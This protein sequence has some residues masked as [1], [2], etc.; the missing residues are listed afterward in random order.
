MSLIPAFFSALVKLAVKSTQRSPRNSTQPSL[1]AGNPHPSPRRFRLGAPH[2][3][4]RLLTFA[5]AACAVAGAQSGAT[6]FGLVAVG[7]SG[8][9]AITIANPSTGTVNSVSVLTQGQSGLDFL[10]GSGG[11]TCTHASLAT[12]T[13]SVSFAPTVPGLR[14]GAVVLLDSNSN[15]LGT[16]LISGVG[17]GGLGVLLNGSVQTIAGN[18]QP[19]GALGD[20]HAAILARLYIPSGVALDGAGN[21]YIADTGDNRIRM[22]SATTGNIATVAGT[23]AAGNLGDHGLAVNAELSAPGGV[24]IDGAGNIYIADTANN[25]IRMVSAATGTITTVAG[26]GNQGNGGD[27]GQATLASLNGPQSV[28]LDAAGNIWIADTNNNLVREV[29]NGIIATIAGAGGAGAPLDTDVQLGDGGSALNAKLNTPYAV[30]FDTK[31]NWY[32]ADSG[33]NRVRMVNG[34]GIIITIA[35]NGNANTLGDGSAA[36]NAGL[37]APSGLAVDPAG[38]IYIST[39][40]S[41]TN[42]RIRKVNEPGNIIS[43][44]TQNFAGGQYAVS[45]DAPIGMAIDGNGNIFLADSLSLQVKE[46]Q[47]SHFVIDFS[48]AAVRQGQTSAPMTETVENDGNDQL[49][50]NSPVP[51]ANTSGIINAQPD[52]AATTCSFPAI[53]AVDG[54]CKIG[55]VFAP[56]VNPP[57]KNNTNAPET[58]NIDIADDAEPGNQG[59]NSPLAITVWGTASPLN[60]TSITFVNPI[61]TSIDFGAPVTYN[62]N[63]SATGALTGTVTLTDVLPS[64]PVTLASLVTVNSANNATLSLTAAQSASLLPVGPHLI[65][66]CYVVT[67]DP[68]HTGSCTTDAQGNPPAPTPPLALT[69]M[70]KTQIVVTSDT[71]SPSAPGQTIT[72]TA[73]LTISGGGGVTPTGSV[74]FYDGATVLNSTPLIVPASGIVTYAYVPGN[75]LHSVTAVYSPDANSQYI[76]GSTSSAL[77]QNVLAPSSITLVSSSL[78]PVYGAPVTYTVTVSPPPAGAAGTEKVN[79]L[80]NGL[81]P[82]AAVA[83]AAGTWTFTSNSL[84]VG[85]DAVTAVYLGD[86]NLAPATSTPVN[87]TVS[88][89][90]TTIQV[91]APASAVSGEPVTLTATVTADLPSTATP[92]GTVT[93][94]NGT[95]NLGAGTGALVNGAIT[96][97]PT[98]YASPTAYSIVVTYTP[99]PI[100]GG[101]DFQPQSY[102][103]SLP[104]PFL[105]PTVTVT[106]PAASPTVKTPVP[107]TINVTGAGP[108]PTGTVI[109]N[110]VTDGASSP[111]VALVNGAATVTWPTAGFTGAATYALTATYLPNGDQNY[112]TAQSKSY[113]LQVVPI[114]TQTS[115]DVTPTTSSNPQPVVV[116]SVSSL[117]P[118][119]PAP[120]SEGSVT[121]MS[122]TTQL[123]VVPV[124][125]GFATLPPLDLPSTVTTVTASYS[126]ANPEVYGPSAAAAVTIQSFVTDF[127][128]KLSTTSIALKPSQNVNITVTLTP[129]N[130]FSEQMALG[131][132]SLPEGVT[133][134]FTM[135]DSSTPIT[136]LQKLTGSSPLVVNLNIDTDN[137]LSGGP[138][139]ANTHDRGSRTV[140]AALF[141]PFS[142]LFGILLW[143]LRKRNAFLATSLLLLLL[144]SSATL[145]NGCGGLSQSSAKPGTYSIQVIAS[146]FNSSNTSSNISHSQTVALTIQ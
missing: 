99:T 74:T 13:F 96:I 88:A 142:L 140:L 71:P 90:P 77:H 24:A 129:M 30:A 131:C 76:L 10:A 93:F 117:N 110:D 106:L 125:S 114:L 119:F 14:V 55:V 115:L 54:I 23:G 63:I 84:P 97:T 82:Q 122:G 109:L 102:T 98:L 7:S 70:E 6:T 27:G 28:S 56:A 38:N 47:S 25:V 85:A 103:L 11:D 101:A 22:V 19:Q 95:T 126:E 60:S 51:T 20:G 72:F 87:E 69:V 15:V 61:P 132:G 73:T 128:M 127:T 139:A 40:G 39:Q 92:A 8:Q 26:N 141:W 130:G 67:N 107:V 104:V 65:Q 136:T 18:G 3:A 108:T 91:A 29:T 120:I 123:A 46:I 89:A 41:S 145:V 44:V 5:L 68:A 49:T 64:N 121:F 58:S 112:L 135:P 138:T 4:G 12:C 94:M 43:T 81:N 146:G 133:C 35:G 134:T 59:T 32:I 100:A 86:A 83:G 48:G 143:R 111:A 2:E 31:G 116:A 75:G 52:L 1:E 21:L 62:V 50:L 80:V 36:T 42:S 144:G 79:I 78:N 16:T 53:L 37:I 34:S 9:Q 66:A 45:L 105:T 137:P 57:L 17:K 124:Q 118:S 113:S 33:D